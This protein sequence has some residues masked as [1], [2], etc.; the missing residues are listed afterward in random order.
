MSDDTILVAER[1]GAITRRAQRRGRSAAGARRAD[2]NR[3]GP[4]R[5]GP[6]AAPGLRTQPRR[7]YQLH[8]AAR[9]A[10]RRAASRRAAS[11]PRGRTRWSWRGAADDGGGRA[12][13]LGRQ[14]VH[15]HEGHLRGRRRQRR[16]DRVRRRRHAVRRARRRRY[17]DAQD[18]SAARSCGSRTRARCHPT[19]RSSAAP[20]PGPKSS[21]WA[22]ARSFGWRSTRSPARSGRSRT[23]RTAETR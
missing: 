15:R 5:H 12:C 7:L 4:V 9:P 13:S 19:I 23:G 20:T 1:G 16:P 3:G 18:A 2:G 22:T 11:R 6:G 8:Q 14:G 21:R 10:G 17:A